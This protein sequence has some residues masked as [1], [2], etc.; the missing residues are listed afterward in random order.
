MNKYIYI[1]FN[2][3]LLILLMSPTLDSQ[4]WQTK[5]KWRNFH[6]TA[7]DSIKALISDSLASVTVDSVMDNIV[8]DDTTLN[9][10]NDTL[11]INPGGVSSSQIKDSS[12]VEADLSSALNAKLIGG[13]TTIDP[14]TQIN[15]TGGNT[16]EVLMDNGPLAIWSMI[17][18]MS[19]NANS[20][21]N[22]KMADSSVGT[23][24]VIDSSLAGNDIGP[25][26]ISGYHLPLD[27]VGSGLSW[28]VIDSETRNAKVDSLD[29][30]NVLDEG[31]GKRDLSDAVYD[32]IAGLY[33]SPTDLDSSNITNNSISKNDL[34]SSVWDSL[35]HGIEDYVFAP[36]P[37]SIDTFDSD[38]L[39]VIDSLASD[40]GTYA[41]FFK[42]IETQD[43]R[44]SVI[45]NY[46]IDIVWQP[47][48]PMS[49]WGGTG[50]PADVI[51]VFF[52]DNAGDSTFAHWRFSVYNIINSNIYTSSWYYAAEAETWESKVFQTTDF[53]PA[54]NVPLRFRLEIRI[55]NSTDSGEIQFKL[56]YIKCEYQSK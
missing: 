39:A 10:D 16:Y 8:V 54:K 36:F 9:K 48:E 43:T 51:T 26:A 17:D 22:H 30:T 56:G 52:T 25:E 20:V 34:A 15:A 19:L 40:A 27:F 28:N 12:I 32:T 50:D 6:P 4:D 14:E 2:I 23:N 3:I 11:K 21:T 53:T 37:S 24:E 5:I 45:Q 18:S 13:S 44:D 47:K 1:L 29:S 38:S 55:A 33:S 31:I 49:A 46:L 35:N 7:V 42:S 41:F